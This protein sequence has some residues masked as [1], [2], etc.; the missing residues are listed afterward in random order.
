M[1]SPYAKKYLPPFWSCSLAPY[2]L[3][4][5]IRIIAKLLLVLLHLG[6]VLFLRLL[7]RQGVLVERLPGVV[8]CLGLCVVGVSVSLF[9]DIC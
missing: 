6:H 8:L 5:L 3:G 2:A 4:R 1:N 7:G 9:G